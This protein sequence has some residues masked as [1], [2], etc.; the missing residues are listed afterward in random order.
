MQMHAGASTAQQS[1]A[2]KNLLPGQL[3]RHAPVCASVLIGHHSPELY[4][5]QHEG[6]RGSVAAQDAAAC[7]RLLPPL[8]PLLL[9][10]C[11][12]PLWPVCPGTQL[13][14][15]GLHCIHH[16]IIAHI[17]G[18]LLDY[19]ATWAA[20]VAHAGYF[21]RWLHV[22]YPSSPS[23]VAGAAGSGQR[24]SLR[25]SRVSSSSFHDFRLLLRPLSPR[26]P[27]PSQLPAEATGAA[28][29]APQ[30]E[31]VLGVPQ[32][33]P[34][35]HTQST[36]A[37]AAGPPSWRARSAQQQQGTAAAGGTLLVSW[38]AG[39]MRNA[40]QLGRTSRA[41]LAGAASKRAGLGKQGA[42]H[43][44][45]P[46]RQEIGRR[47]SHAAPAPASAAVPSQYLPSCAC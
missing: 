47:W 27:A 3:W 37:S 24:P 2:K 11:P 26:L 33:R 46:A 19:P 34:G 25:S 30:A 23:K 8:P 41:E 20:C 21:R 5:H 45:C 6:R 18:C 29:A 32:T 43:S 12:G 10:P 36:W 38:T 1:F 22:L 9:F 4:R 13:S 7:C 35:Q 40:S 31:H 17:A 39:M 44:A 42:L 16:C 15:Q 28:A 14:M